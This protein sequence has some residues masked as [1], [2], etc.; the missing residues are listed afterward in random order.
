MLQ[1]GTQVSWPRIPVCLV[2]RY[3]VYNGQKNAF[4]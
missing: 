2:E 4:W 1:A 3:R